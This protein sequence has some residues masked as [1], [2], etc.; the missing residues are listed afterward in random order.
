M[1]I[2]SVID[3]NPAPGSFH[4]QPQAETDRES[5]AEL[6]RRIMAGDHDAEAEL[7]DRYSR[8]VSF[9]IRRS[10]HDRAA[11]ED[12]FQDTMRLCLVKVRGGE[13]REPERLSGFISSLARNLVTDHFRKHSR[14][15]SCEVSQ[16]DRPIPAPEPSPLAKLMKEEEGMLARRALA[17]MTSD[18]DR[19]VLYRF[20]LADDDKDQICADLGLSSLHFN[21]ILCRARERFK[22]A[23]LDMKKEENVQSR[24]GIDR[25]PLSLLQSR[26]EG[27]YESFP[28][29]KEQPDRALRLR[30]A[31]CGQRLGI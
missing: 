17:A 25:G 15:R 1:E 21:Q 10:T 6:V 14:I 26:P 27:L 13:V 12:L 23:F 20:Y 11:A 19:T 3:S 5:P 22:K 31:D 4:L 28:H 29:R 8:G 16:E 9:V 7:V 2:Q 24:D 30:K 18:R